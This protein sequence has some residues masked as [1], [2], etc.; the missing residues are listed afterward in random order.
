MDVASGA[1]TWVEW[2]LAEAD[3]G[4]PF[5]I[6]PVTFNEMVW[7]IYVSMGRSDLFCCMYQPL[8]Q[9]KEFRLA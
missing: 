5:L 6:C 2:M 1:V 4:M 9:K 7:Q 3:F 8:Q